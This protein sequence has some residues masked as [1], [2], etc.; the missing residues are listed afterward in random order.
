M[1]MA[2]KN[3][4]GHP[5]WALLLVAGPLL[6]GLYGGNLFIDDAYIS[7]RYAANL[8][9]GRGFVYNTTPVLGATSPLYILLLAGLKL[10]GV[11]ITTSGLAI[12]VLATAAAPV[13]V[14]RTGAALGRTGAG[15][16]GGLLLA[17][18]PSWW[19][20]GKTGMESTLAGLFAIAVIWLDLKRRPAL[21]GLV[22]GAL[23]LTRPDSAL[24]PLIVFL[25]RL[26]KPRR[27]LV[28]AAA[29][30]AVVLPWVIFAWSYFG[31]PLPQS[32]AAK[33]LIHVYPFGLGL[34]SN[35]GWF[36]SI[37]TPP[38]LLIL[39]T[40]CFLAGAAV[41][42]LRQRDGLAVVLWPPLFIVGL[43]ATGV[44]T[45][46]WYRYPLLPVYFLGAG[47]GL[48]A[49]GKVIEQRRSAIRAPLFA[50]LIAIPSLYTFAQLDGAVNWVADNEAGKMVAKERVMAQMADEI[51]HQE[52]VRR[53]GARPSIFAG[54]VGVLGYKLPDFEMIDS[55][56][57]NSIE[58]Y[59]IR[60]RD[61][62]ALKAAHPEFDWRQQWWG[63]PAW[64]REVIAR[65]RPDY[66]AS[67]VNYLYLRKLLTEAA[68][69]KEYEAIKTWKTPGGGF[70]LLRRSPQAK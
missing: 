9:A 62:E 31:S 32:L 67:D 11:P 29:A 25:L 46:F 13:V 53:S 42:A 39:I 23:V 30:S 17:L 35:L 34:I 69:L 49:A 56:G 64:S 44:G 16:L 60:R 8:A 2:E 40:G 10:L 7:F 5:A 61:W 52:S 57:I 65:F 54:E 38:V 47:I 70:L 24:L 48:G 19:L 4:W 33:K 15:L 22:A 50:V 43:A 18:T 59:E 51:L 63:S 27:P 36:V 66:I 6:A 55:A 58:V 41:L 1:D 37:L 21:A 45:F 20:V 14:W 3:R 68:F 26:R 12:G 28:F